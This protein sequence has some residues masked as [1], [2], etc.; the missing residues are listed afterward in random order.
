METVADYT[1]IIDII[2][3][4]GGDAFKRCFQCGLC[5][6]VCPWNRVKKPMGTLVSSRQS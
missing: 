1:E 4:N 3:E 6:A 5:D 2:K